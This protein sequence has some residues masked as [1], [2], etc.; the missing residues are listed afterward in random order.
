VSAATD[1]RTRTPPTTATTTT[2][3][4]MNLTTRSSR[5]HANS[6][7]FSSSGRAAKPGAGLRFISNANSSAVVVK[8]RRMSAVKRG[9]GVESMEHPVVHHVG[10]PVKAP[11]DPMVPVDT[12][13][14][15]AGLVLPLPVPR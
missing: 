8:N 5:H 2:T 10:G 9:V 11:V 14:I 3:T 6:S 1:A 7:A 4:M 12:T 15:A 13:V